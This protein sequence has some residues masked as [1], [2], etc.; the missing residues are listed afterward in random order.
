VAT[1]S[2]RFSLYRLLFALARSLV[3]DAPAA[4][5]TRLAALPKASTSIEAGEQAP[6]C[7]GTEALRPVADD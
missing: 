4:H 5:R 7:H 3:V 1:H 6:T 2:P